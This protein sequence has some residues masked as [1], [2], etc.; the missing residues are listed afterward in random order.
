ML[1]NKVSGGFKEEGFNR[2]TTK[3]VG[4]TTL[5]VG[6]QRNL[7]IYG[8]SPVSAISLPYGRGITEHRE[9]SSS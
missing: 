6:V 1:G 5:R 2:S 4:S 8:N 3:I 9:A 7:N